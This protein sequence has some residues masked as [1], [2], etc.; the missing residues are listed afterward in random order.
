MEI[1]LNKFIRTTN[2]YEEAS[3]RYQELTKIKESREH[4]LAKAPEG[5][6]HIV[7]AKG[8]CVQF[9]LRENKGEKSGRYIPKSEIETIKTFAQKMY[10]ERLL[11]IVGDELQALQILNKK[12]ESY[13][14]KIRQLYSGAPDEVKSVI[15]PV[16][17]SDEDYAKMWM[18][19]PFERKEIPEYLPLY[20]T[21]RKERVR[22]KSELTIAN[23]LD[24]LGIPYKYECPLTLA[25]GKAIY[26]D[27]T[28]LHVKKRKIFYW[29]H[30]GMMDD[31]EYATQAVFK[32]KQLRKSGISLGNNLILTEET[33]A[34]PLGTDEIRAVIQQ[35]L[36]S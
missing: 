8:R 9:Y 29:E 30:R 27:F 1:R 12:S 19:I 25:N 36:Q 35:F 7:S 11:K 14:N 24:S 3:R 32:V 17:I 33:T 22:S 34:D 20:E 5:K 2:L 28:L 26:P 15:T 31:R 4:S 23:T 21:K 6:I 13:V 18:A 10:D 16:D